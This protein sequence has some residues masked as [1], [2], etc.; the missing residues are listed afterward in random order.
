MDNFKLINFKILYYFQNFIYRKNI[1]FWHKWNPIIL[2]ILYVN[3]FTS[4]LTLILLSVRNINRVLTTVSYLFE[5]IVGLD[6]LLFILRYTLLFGR[7]LKFQRISCWKF[8][9]KNSFGKI[10]LNIAFNK[11]H[12]IIINLIICTDRILEP[13]GWKIVLSS[14]R[15]M[16]RIW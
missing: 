9:L 13:N 6:W 7:L 10:L 16:I 4:I 2:S 3:W 8:W 14:W 5:F 12:K 15:F 11:R 1:I